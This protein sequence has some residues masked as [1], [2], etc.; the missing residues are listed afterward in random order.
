[1]MRRKPDAQFVIGISADIGIA[2]PFKA[3]L[4]KGGI[5]SYQT[6]RERHSVSV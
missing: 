3:Q 5:V 1:M 6:E 2:I 4:K